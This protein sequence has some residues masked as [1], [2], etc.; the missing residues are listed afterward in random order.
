MSSDL[1]IKANNPR[2]RPPV[3]STR[4]QNVQQDPKQVTQTKTQATDKE[5]GG[6]MQTTVETVRTALEE[7]LE[8]MANDTNALHFSVDEGNSSIV[9]KVINE[10]TDEVVREIRLEKLLGLGQESSALRGVF[11]LQKA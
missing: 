8:Q 6:G 11:V 3:A 9:V 4:Q 7:L 1:A 2:Y 5:D 10:A